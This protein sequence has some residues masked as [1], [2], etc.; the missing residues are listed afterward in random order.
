MRVRI[1]LLD[2]QT[3][4]AQNLEVTADATA[5]A[6]DVA[7][8]LAAG[9]DAEK[10]RGNLTLNVR[11]GNVSRTL[12]PAASIL[13]AGLRSGQT[14]ELVTAA[15]LG[16]NRVSS[17]SVAVV[18]VID[19]V[20]RGVEVPLGI[21]ESTIGRSADRDVRLTDPLVS[22][23][24]ARVTVGE[25]I[26]LTDANSANG[27]LVGGVQVN[28]VTVRPGDVV[29]LGDTRITITPTR[30]LTANQSTSTDVTFTRSPRV[31]RRPA[32]REFELPRPPS[33]ADS[34][35]FP[36][37]AMVA[38]LVMGVVLYAFTRNL[39]SIVFVALSPL[40]MVSTWWTQRN[41]SRR[42]T[43][44][45]TDNFHSALMSMGERLDAALDEE[46]QLRLK[47]YPSAAESVRAIIDRTELLWS[48]RPEHP[49]FLR[50]RLGLGEIRPTTTVKE[51]PT[52]GLPD[53]VAQA[54]ELATSRSVLTEAPITADLRSAG[55]VGVCGSSAQVDGVARA[56][57]TQVV[58]LHSPA[59]VVV[60]CLTSVRHRD[61]W[62]WLQWLPHCDSPQSPLRGQHLSADPGSGSVL[63]AQV[64]ELLDVRVEATARPRGPG[65]LDED[66]PVL[67]SVVLVVDDTT[68]D[69]ARLTRIAERGPDGGVYVLWVANARRD[70]PA[71]CRAFI[72]VDEGRS[73]TANL[74]REEVPDAEVTPE[75]I[76]ADVA[77]S[78]AR[79]LAP[80]V[81]DSAVAEDDSD[82]P[83]SVSIASLLGA[84]EC[85]DADIVLTRWRENQSLIDRSAPPVPRSEASSLRALVGHAGTEPFTLDLRSQ[86]PH[87]LVGGTTGA[88][89]SEFLQSWVLGMAHAYSPDRVSFLFVDYK[90]GAAFARCTDLPHSVGIVTD[91]TPYLVRRAL[92]SLRAELHR[93]ERLLNEKGKKD[94]LELEASGDHECPPSLVIVVDEFA[95]LAGEVPEFVDGV[96]DVAQRG[97]SLGLHLILATQRPAG[98]IKD[99]LRANTNLRI[100]LRMADEHDSTDVVGDKQ[101]ADFPP[102]I[103]GRGVARTGPGRL[104]RFQS[105]FPGSRTPAI[106]PTPPIDIVEMGFGAKRP[107]TRPRTE[108]VGDGVRK[109]ID[110]VVDTL[111]AAVVRAGVPLPRR[112]WLESLAPVYNLTRLGQRR[113]TE[114]VLGVRD[115]PDKQDQP[116]DRFLPDAQGNIVFYGVSG[117]GKSTALRSLAAASAI[118]PRSGPVHTYALDFAGGALRSLEALPTVG[119]VIAGDDDD[120][121]QRLLRYVRDVIEERAT[122]YS[123]SRAAN[124]TEYRELA[125]HPDEPR[126]LLL[127]DGFGAFRA[128]YEGVLGRDAYYNLFL[129]ILADGRAVGVHVAMTADRPNV[130]PVSA[131]SA[132]LK[133]IVLRQADEDAYY[134]LSVPR[135]VLTAQS[136][137]GRGIDAE[138]EQELQLAI[139]GTSVNVAV[140]A[141][142][143]EAFGLDLAGRHT[144]RPAA[145]KSLP[146]IVPSSGQA[147]SIGGRPVVGIRDDTLTVLG[148]DPRGA[149]LVCGP[150]QSGR[151]DAL[152]WMAEAVREACPAVRMIHFSARRSQLSQ[153]QYWESTSIGI[154]NVNDAAAQL[155]STANLAAPETAPG[156]CVVIEAYPDFISS[157]ADPMLLEL[158]KALRRNGHLVI[159]EGETSGWNSWPLSMEIRNSGTGLLLSPDQQDGEMV[160][161]TALP[162][163]KRADFPPG[164]GFWI[165]SGKAVKVQ[166]PLVE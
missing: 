83:R 122:R 80:V 1:A 102:S 123:A 7:A 149:V 152:R 150:G 62:E 113:D 82:L 84:Q 6:A 141:R 92:R 90:G 127:L 156:I 2:K 166:V 101:A 36:L 67:P 13:Q 112:P 121:V 89:K 42:R 77:H 5:T 57:L 46:R 16:G 27:V 30:S 72:E 114:I 158:V 157:P 137:P 81:D 124:L 29:Q 41:H 31:M 109:D 85:D 107:W 75:T 21:G 87:A 11:E 34:Q 91:L 61:R 135:D 10:A 28:S 70:L 143:L 45:A 139:L 48:R 60:A 126:I 105:G 59:D 145:I 130:V 69:R 160:L 79:S 22:K 111:N 99:N 165:Q 44:A 76:G 164:R 65:V 58:G 117:T 63:L 32:P 54:R 110:R 136:P 125:D 74:V 47:L 154:E 93:R 19:G 155:I 20:D 163:V 97:R 43:A 25:A 86:G 17:E 159:A 120:R 104:V 129:R 94:L 116:V 138:T 18:R 98:V 106:A 119:S 51:A 108:V 118:T 161:R 9:P 3:G 88:G 53:L 4:A 64:E 115:D 40:M 134:A 96:V 140:Q 14:V 39:L 132:F 66:K 35:P 131:S 95:A 73:P 147:K 24:H 162:R 78:V 142:D 15:T 144:S 37:L 103:P 100:A 52:D 56:V 71:A 50:I 38:P 128:E 33:R 49:E 23:L 148:F 153:S 151:T 26:E 12:N 8:A 68:V 55:G 133:R 146:A